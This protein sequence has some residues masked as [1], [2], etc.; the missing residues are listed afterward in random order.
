[1]SDLCS[2]QGKNDR[3]S[4]IFAIASRGVTVAVVCNFQQISQSH[5]HGQKYDRE[6][7]HKE[8]GQTQITG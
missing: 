4:M 5:I 6:H 3:T 2:Y 8:D 1:M 7:A